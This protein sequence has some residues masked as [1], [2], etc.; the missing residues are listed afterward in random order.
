MRPL[1]RISLL[2]LFLSCGELNQQPSCAPP[3]GKI[4]CAITKQ[5]N[6]GYDEYDWMYESSCRSGNGLTRPAPC[7]S[8]AGK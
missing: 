4:C 8:C 7:S 5:M 1:A 2:A 6:G 3:P